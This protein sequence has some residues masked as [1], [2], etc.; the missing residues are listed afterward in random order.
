MCVLCFIFLAE[1]II[2]VSKLECILI[3]VLIR[4]YGV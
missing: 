4:S 1:I 2:V 3:N